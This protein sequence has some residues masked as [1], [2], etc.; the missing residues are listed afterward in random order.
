MICRF[1]CESGKNGWIVM[2]SDTNT[3]IWPKLTLLKRP[4]ALSAAL[5]PAKGLP[6]GK[7]PCGDTVRADPGL[8]LATAPRAV[9][10]VGRSLAIPPDPAVHVAALKVH[11]DPLAPHSACLSILLWGLRTGR[12]PVAPRRVQHSRGLVDRGLGRQLQDVV[13]FLSH[14]REYRPVWTANSVTAAG[15]RRYIARVSLRP[16]PLQNEPT[17]GMARMNC[18]NR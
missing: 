2:I 11:P 16:C 18:Q 6:G 12:R 10:G 9:A 14:T 5:L 4:L 8:D 13:R 3:T 7:E 1:R 17:G 15:T